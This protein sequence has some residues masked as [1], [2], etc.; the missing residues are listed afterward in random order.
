MNNFDE[1]MMRR[2]FQLA[3]MAE[4]YTSP[5]PLVG[6][7]IVNNGKI[8]GEGYHHRAG[9][10]HAEPNAIHSVADDKLLESSTLY[11]SLEPCSHWGKTPPC[12]SLIIEKK[13][14]RVVVAMLDPNP[15][16]SGRGVKMMQEA[17]IDVTVGLL[18]AEARWIN[19]RFLS[20]QE[21][22]RPY[23]ILKWAETAD[24]FIDAA[25]CSEE[26]KPLRISNN[27]TKTLNHHLRATEDAIMV[28]TD[29]ACLDNPHLTITKWAGQNP[30][31]VILDRTCRIPAESRIFDSAATTVI[32]T[33]ETD[34][35]KY[36][37]SDDN[38]KYIIVD[39]DDNLL[40]QIFAHLI[41]E[42]INS[43]II[44]GG[45]R[46]LQ[47]VIDS[48]LW[49]EARVETAPTKIGCGTPGPTINGKIT[50]VDH[51][52]QNIITTVTPL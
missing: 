46:W 27:I 40:P 14:P 17:G 31:R 12:A 19:R 48:G 13:I 42:N 8:I 50:R 11:V 4:G 44:E 24:H 34:K 7:V 45:S 26:R 30:T 47:T 20:V 3:L 33:A 37:T 6:A 29:T 1:Q 18:E 22:H 25:R 39:F 41:A 23:V 43:V 9:M 51:F 10:P 5:N 32:F 52:G 28:A 36:Q 15:K 35:T 49:D 2:C 21:H 16:V 38:V